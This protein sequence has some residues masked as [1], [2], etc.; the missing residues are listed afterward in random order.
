MDGVHEGRNP[1]GRRECPGAFKVNRDS[2]SPLYG[3]QKLWK[4]NV[5]RGRIS[6][7]S[8]NLRGLGAITMFSPPKNVQKQD[9]YSMAQ[10]E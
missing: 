10:R 4:K 6:M 7:G 9:L 3:L 8:Q 1:R 2:V 5:R